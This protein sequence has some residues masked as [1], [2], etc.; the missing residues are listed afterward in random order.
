MS[1]V[2]RVRCSALATITPT[3]GRNVAQAQRGLAGLAPAQVGQR[4]VQVAAAAQAGQVGR[5]GAMAHEQ[6]MHGGGRRW[7]RIG[8]SSTQHVRRKTQRRA[9]MAFARRGMQHAPFRLGVLPAAQQPVAHEPIWLRSASSGAWPVSGRCIS[10][11]SLPRDMRRIVG[12][13]RHSDC[14]PWISSIGQRTV[15]HCSHCC[16]LF[17]ASRR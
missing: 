11:I 4:H 12:S 15:L 8:S 13:N 17:C 7:S 5:G 9:G 1:A 14:M 10:V 3:G 16:R 2:S 6:Q